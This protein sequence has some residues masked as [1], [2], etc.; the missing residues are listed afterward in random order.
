MLLGNS[1]DWRKADLIQNS[2]LI[3][4][5]LAVNWVDCLEGF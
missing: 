4:G 2:K 3:T 1:H 5:A